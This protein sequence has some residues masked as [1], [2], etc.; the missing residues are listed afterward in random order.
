MFGPYNVIRLKV[1]V[2][3]T[4]KHIKSPSRSFVWDIMKQT[5]SN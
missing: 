3:F 2:V 5:F 1:E 4:I